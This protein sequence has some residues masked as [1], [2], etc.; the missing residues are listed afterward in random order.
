MTTATARV[1]VAAPAVYEMGT[2]VYVKPDAPDRYWP[3][4]L[5]TVMRHDA[6]T[7]I[8]T[9]HSGSRSKKAYIPA[10]WLQK[11]KPKGEEKAAAAVEVTVTPPPVEAEEAPAIDPATL[12]LE[13]FRRRGPPDPLKGKPA[14]SFNSKS[15]GLNK[16][17]MNLL[18][19]PERIHLAFDTAKHVIGITAAA[20]SDLTA[21]V[22]VRYTSKKGDVTGNLRCMGFYNRFGITPPKAPVRSLAILHGMQLLAVF[23]EGG[24]A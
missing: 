1:R 5:V 6:H 4:E 16:E 19:R 23:T 2:P 21:L 15:L 14:I 10:V 8:Y 20:A 11:D 24:G 22:L 3:G 7:F 13:P 18:G 12:N 17:A 9:V